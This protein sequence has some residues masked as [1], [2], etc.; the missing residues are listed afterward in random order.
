MVTLY[1][2]TWQ[3]VT[4]EMGRNIR[5]QS[6]VKSG[7]QLSCCLVSSISC[8]TSHLAAVCTIFESAVCI[9]TK[10]NFYLVTQTGVGMRILS[11]IVELYRVT[12]HHHISRVISGNYCS[13]QT[14][15]TTVQ[16]RLSSRSNQCPE[17]S[18][19]DDICTTRFRVGAFKSQMP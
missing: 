15:T 10:Y 6:R 14:A 2:A 9:W 19:W 1:R 4:Q 17:T 13:C 3:D 18:S 8:A 12:I 16:F 5:Q 11:Y 7:H